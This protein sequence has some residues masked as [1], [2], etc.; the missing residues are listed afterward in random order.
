MRPTTAMHRPPHRSR[1]LRILLVE[2]HDDTRRVLARL[3][4]H[5]GHHISVA[6]G[7]SDALDIFGAEEFDVVLSDIGLPDGTGYDVIAEAKRTRDV[8]GVA[9]TGFGMAEDVR[10]SKEAGFDFHL[11]KPIDVA[12]LRNVLSKLR[13]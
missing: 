6:V 12:E 8:K 11:T 1:M 4:T 2:D 13:V 9:L 3:L 7:V 10:R 5:F